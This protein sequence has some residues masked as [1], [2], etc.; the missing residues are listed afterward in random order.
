MAAQTYRMA[1]TETAHEYQPKREIALCVIL[2]LSLLVL[3][4]RAAKLVWLDNPTN[5]RW[6][7]FDESIGTGRKTNIAVLDHTDEGD[8][9]RRRTQGV[10]GV[11]SIRTNGRPGYI[12]VVVQPWQQFRTWLGSSN[13]VTLTVRYFDSAPGKLEIRYDSSDL[14]VKVNSYPAGV[15]R[16]PDAIPHGLALTGDRKWKTLK[17]C[18]PFALFTKRV[19]GADLRIEGL[20]N[21]FA[22]AGIALTRIPRVP[23]RPQTKKV[24]IVQNSRFKI[25]LDRYGINAIHNKFSG[26]LVSQAAEMHDSLAMI[27]LKKPGASP[28]FTKDFYD[29]TFEGCEILGTAESPVVKLS[30]RFDIGLQVTTTGILAPD[31]QSEWRLVVKNPTDFEIAEVRF[32]VLA[33]ISLGGDPTNDWLFVPEILGAGYKI[34]GGRQY[35]GEYGRGHADAL[36]NY[37]G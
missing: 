29:A 32:P 3:P 21:G 24:C 26:L 36:G 25:E 7:D 16:N 28:V 19:H 30:H 33:G 17:V 15:W 22:V 12:Y 27:T 37:V 13:D 11:Q 20:V 31:G 5:S 35:D 4:A 18:L 14:R 9:I 2:V 34:S 8:I 23:Y 10:V 6:V 1:R